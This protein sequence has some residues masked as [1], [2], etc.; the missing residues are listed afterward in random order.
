VGLYLAHATI[1]RLGGE[2]T[3]KKRHRGGTNV[4]IM[5]PL[6]ADNRGTSQSI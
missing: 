1:Q 6:L 2:L 5:L 4:R 3:I